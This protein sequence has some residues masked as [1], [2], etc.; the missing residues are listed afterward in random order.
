MNPLEERMGYKFRNGLLLAEALTHPSI[1]LERKNYPFD[2][3]RLEFLGD[4]VIQLVVTEHLYRL[5]PDFSEGQ[6]TKLRTRIVSRPAL[7]AH[8]VLMD[9]GRY[10]MMGRGEEASGGRE[11]AS[12]LA[13]AF[14]S[15]VGAIYL[16]GGFD[17]ARNFVLRETLDDFERIAKNPEEVNPK[18]TLQEI[19]QAI[20]PCAPAY[21]VVEQTGP[22]HSKHFVSKVIWSEIELGRGEGLS[23][24]Q[25]QVAAASDALDRQLWLRKDKRSGTAASV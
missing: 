1:S 12:T 24:K 5:Y 23:K 18:G 19:L 7:K 15:V 17:A 8:A 6:M 3:Q 22:D 10:L 9:L 2:N 16:D 11:R 21:E 4:A 13:D 25:A 14:E 20:E